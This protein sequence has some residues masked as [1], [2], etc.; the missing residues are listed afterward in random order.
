MIFHSK[1]H[2]FMRKV[3]SFI[4]LACTVLAACQKNTGMAGEGT[5]PVTVS[6]TGSISKVT[7]LNPADEVKVNSLQ[8]LV[9]DSE[10]NI[11]NYKQAAE[12]E[13][14]VTMSITVGAK[15]IYALLNAP[16]LGDVASEAALLGMSSLM[17]DNTI[18]S[19]V[20]TGSVST[21][22]SKATTVEIPVKRMVAK[23]I[24]KKITAAFE[25]AEMASEDMFLK[26]IYM[27][28]VPMDMN[29][30]IDAVPSARLSGADD[31]G[32]VNALIADS[33]TGVNLKGNAAYTTEHNFFIYPTGAGT[34]T[35]AIV[36][37]AEMFGKPQIYTC[38]LPQIERNKTYEVS[39][40]V[41][42]RLGGEAYQVTC[43]IKIEGWDTGLSDYREEF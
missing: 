33:I 30:G 40:L 22:I 13:T 18:G 21:T 25:S 2:I 39:E 42:T 20:M 27:Q 37:E 5:V 19:F 4:A 6:V 24:L 14:S 41:I 17:S 1:H 38:R 3:F 10:G 11:Q 12:G 15:H 9:F 29:Y 8:I 36:I 16:S 43:D 7:G 35:P 28:D 34:V 31:N 23:V 32:A 26:R